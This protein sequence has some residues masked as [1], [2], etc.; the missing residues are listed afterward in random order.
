MFLQ[1][2]VQSP[3]NLGRTIRG[4]GRPRVRPRVL[5]QPD[6]NAVLLLWVR[7][8]SAMP[9]KTTGLRARGWLPERLRSVF[10]ATRS[11]TTYRNV[12]RV[13]DLQLSGWKLDRVK[14]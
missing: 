8:R 11:D 1:I 12:G 9:E 13:R 2:L 14:G 4:K 7:S 5:V 6:R 10:E 3:T